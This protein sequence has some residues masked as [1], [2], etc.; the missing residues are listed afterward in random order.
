MIPLR[1]VCAPDGAGFGTVAGRVRVCVDRPMSSM[2]SDMLQR[3]E[4]RPEAGSDEL[5]KTWCILKAE[6]SM[7]GQ[8]YAPL[9][10]SLPHVPADQ[11]AAFADAELTNA[12]RG[13]ASI[14][15][16]SQPY[17]D[18]TGRLGTDLLSHILGMT[19]LAETGRAAATCKAMR[20]CALQDGLWRRHACAIFRSERGCSSLQ[21][22][23]DAC[24]VAQRA[25]TQMARQGAT[26]IAGWYVWARFVHDVHRLASWAA[27]L[28]VF[29][30]R[31]EGRMPGNRSD[32]R[33]GRIAVDV[34]DARQRLSRLQLSDY[35]TAQCMSSPPVEL[36]RAWAL[37]RVLLE[38]AVDDAAMPGRGDAV[39]EEGI[40]QLESARS[41]FVQQLGPTLSNR[42]GEH[43]QAHIGGFV[44]LLLNFDVEAVPTT[45]VDR[46]AKML[47]GVSVTRIDARMQELLRKSNRGACGPTDEFRALRVAS[48]ITRWAVA[49]VERSMR[50]RWLQQIAAVRHALCAFAAVLKEPLAN[51]PF[52]VAEVPSDGSGS[53][54]DASSSEPDGGS[55][56]WAEGGGTRSRRVSVHV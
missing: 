11:D 24:G 7:Q 37:L 4:L 39:G 1:P 13:A 55:Y 15:R 46:A 54:S 23:R 36:L 35:R 49:T 51:E 41:W 25:S 9:L 10:A 45:R 12:E 26:P 6:V 19:S 48:A 16:N 27:V 38:D 29:L 43:A 32:H 5:V 50:A 28:D 53:E 30:D 34:S 3:L 17:V 22:L 33:G 2:L 18:W 52:L 56:R 31:L 47:P 8:R 21:P 42:F 44:S 20:E 40:D 14:D